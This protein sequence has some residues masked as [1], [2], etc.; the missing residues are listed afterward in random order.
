VRNGLLKKRI[1]GK[2]SGGCVRVLVVFITPFLYGMERAVIG[3]FDALRPDID[4]HFVQSSRIFE[5]DPPVIQEMRRRCFSM[6]L[7]PDREDWEPLGRP[8]SL[9]H[10][11]RMVYALV[12]SNITVLK[13]ARGKD[14][15]F[16]PSA[17]AGLMAVC[18]AVMFRASGRRVVHQFHDLGQ[19]IPGSQ[20]WFRLL[21]DCIHTSS[22][23]LKVAED[24]LP[25]IRGKR[26]VVM[27]YIV[28]VEPEV[29]EDVDAQ[30]ILCGKRNVFFVGQVSRYKGVD[31]LLRA[32]E[33]VAREHADVMLHLLG[34]CDE[35]FRDQ[36]NEQVAAAGLIHRVRFWGYRE[37]VLDLLRSA[38]LYVQS[39]PPSR[40]HECFP[41]SVLEAMAVG[42]PTICFRSGGLPEMVIH[43]ETGLVCEESVVALSDALNRFLV[44]KDF[45]DLCAAGAKQRYEE[46]CSPRRMRQPWIQF[47][48][49]KAADL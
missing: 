12:R 46:L 26:N 8:R 4:P 15:L 14:V 23:G 29:R 33:P 34:G 45:R 38:Y 31:L 21:T 11:F 10:L 42:I 18:A 7:L 3:T 24:A 6:T 47:L 5:R 19:P 40:F 36:L 20:L 49:K 9:R 43:E 32:F 48:A 35:D 1:S 28:E 41:R 37:D 30:R 17:R 39:S 16:V 44:D 25:A 13:A 2:Q 22:F 27:P